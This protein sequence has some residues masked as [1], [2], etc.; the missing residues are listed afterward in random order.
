MN[1][2][3]EELLDLI[4]CSSLKSSGIIK[5][6]GFIM[7]TIKDILSSIQSLV[8]TQNKGHKEVN[9]KLREVV[10]VQKRNEEA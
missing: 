6:E 1:A 3:Q 8:E 2:C 4:F 10:E 7:A 9:Q 5:E